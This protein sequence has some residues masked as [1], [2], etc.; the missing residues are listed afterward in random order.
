MAS[1]VRFF[2]VLLILAGFGIASAQTTYALFDRGQFPVENRVGNALVGCTTTNPCLNLANAILN[3]KGAAVIKV[4]AMRFPLISFR[5]Y[6]AGG[7]GGD[8]FA[9]SMGSNVWPV[10]TARTTPWSQGFGNKLIISIRPNP[11]AGS[12]PGLII[13]KDGFGSAPYFTFEFS[14]RL[15]TWSLIQVQLD[16]PSDVDVTLGN[17]APSTAFLTISINSFP[18]VSQLP[19]DNWLP[20]ANWMYLFSSSNFGG[21]DMY[22]IDS[23]AVTIQRPDQ[24]RA[25]LIVQVPTALL[26][27]DRMA[28]VM[29]QAAINTAL[30]TIRGPAF[31]V[32]KGATAYRFGKPRAKRR[33]L[34]QTATDFTIFS[35]EVVFSSSNDTDA[36]TWAR[37]FAQSIVAG[38]A[39]A[40][41]DQQIKSQAASAGWQFPSYTWGSALYSQ[42]LFD[43]LIAVNVYP[44]TTTTATTVSSTV[45][46]NLG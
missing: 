1:F 26:G 22:R 33:N 35:Q 28:A 6:A 39:A 25:Q 31:V 17:L 32:N 45:Y 46:A 8:G 12:P 38:E 14:G 7:T 23:Y 30:L 13:Y 41:F 4:A 18:V 2:V 21:T 19:I 37:L 34:R 16:P 15:P 10:N 40:T 29:P 3:Q 5:L 11:Q 36:S 9:F 27:Y 20:D 43:F 24:V 44:R 42:K